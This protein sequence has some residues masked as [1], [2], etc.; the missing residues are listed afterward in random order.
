MKKILLSLII[1]I[2]AFG[3]ATKVTTIE[4][5]ATKDSIIFVYDVPDTNFNNLKSKPTLYKKLIIK[6]LCKNENAKLL[7]DTMNIVYDY[8]KHSDNTQKV[9][10]KVKRG[11]CEA[12]Q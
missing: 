7:S 10:I 9:V 5:K 11:T 3:G 12:G 6:I 4:K 8:R 1:A 2:F